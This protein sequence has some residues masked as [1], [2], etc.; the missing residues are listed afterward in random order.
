M[1]VDNGPLR[2]KNTGWNKIF[3]RRPS[4]VFCHIYIKISVDKFLKQQK[5]FFKI[6]NFIAINIK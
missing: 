1:D 5:I 3:E 6:L 4:E 2:G